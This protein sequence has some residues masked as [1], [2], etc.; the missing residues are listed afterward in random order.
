[1]SENAHT[2]TYR[3][4]GEHR[5]VRYEPRARGDGYW[6]EEAYHNGCRWVVC[7]RE[8]VADVCVDSAAVVA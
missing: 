3:A 4:D 7:G 8:P 5:R 6:R 2:I 1:M